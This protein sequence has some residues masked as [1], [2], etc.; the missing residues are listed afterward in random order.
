MPEFISM[1]II[2]ITILQQMIKMSMQLLKRF[3]R[4]KIQRKKM[5]KIY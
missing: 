2:Q 5:Q 4:L 1:N 3:K